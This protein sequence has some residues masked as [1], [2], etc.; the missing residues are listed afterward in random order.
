[1]RS[2]VDTAV[3]LGRLVPSNNQRRLVCFDIG[4]VLVRITL[5]IDRAAER[6]GVPGVKGKGSFEN[7]PSYKGYQT[8]QL[9]TESYLEGF[10]RD[11]GLSAEETR[12]VHNGLV[13]GPYAGTEEL[14]RELNDAGI[15]TACLS[16][17]NELHWLH[18]FDEGEIP[19]LQHLT[20]R[21]ASHLVGEEKPNA[22]FYRNLETL[23]GVTSQEILFFDDV[24][25][26]V[27]AASALG[28]E[29]MVI[30]PSGDPAEQMR[31]KLT[32][33]I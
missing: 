14:V 6:V 18:M 10:S 4:G 16:N 26:N 1:M 20:F 13:I 31:Q 33:W 30:D 15:L 5:E 25:L 9:T 32:Q 2:L 21:V 12:R 17:T 22:P 28:W 29:A 7:Y 11:L 8:G 3:R 23:A 24:P 19:A 27:E